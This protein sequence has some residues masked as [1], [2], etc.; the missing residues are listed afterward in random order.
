MSHSNHFKRRNAYILEF[1]D[2]YRKNR[3]EY[4]LRVRLQALA[5]AADAAR[6]AEHASQG[7]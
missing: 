4:D 7:T 1:G 6:R 3:E 2:F 5:M